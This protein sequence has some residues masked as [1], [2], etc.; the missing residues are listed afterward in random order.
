MEAEVFV[1]KKKMIVHIAFDC[2]LISY[3]FFDEMISLLSTTGLKGEC[4]FH[5][6]RFIYP[7]LN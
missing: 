5:G 2:P 4:F 6:Y 7:R 3:G 1:S